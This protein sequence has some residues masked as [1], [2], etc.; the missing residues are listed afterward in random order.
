[1]PENV[2]I[3]IVEDEQ[4][5]AADLKQTLSGL[6]Y[7][8]V[9]LADTGE[10]AIHLASE[11]RPNLVLMDIYLGGSVNGVT[12]AKEINSLWHIP[13]VFLT[14]NSNEEVLVEARSAEPYGYL[15]KPYRVQELDATIRVALQ[16]REAT[17][18]LF[19]RHH[20]LRAILA[21]LSDGV[22]ATDNSGR[23]EYLNSV[24]EHLTGWQLQEAIGKDFNE[25]FAITTLDGEPVVMCQLRKAL[26]MLKPVGRAR[27]VLRSKDGRNTP[28]EDSAAPVLEDGIALGAVSVFFDI[29]ERLGR[30]RE[31]EELKDRLEE[32]VRLT[33]MALG[34][35][36][37]ELRALSGH[38]MTAQEEERRRIARELHDDLAQQASLAEMRLEQLAALVPSSDTVQ[39]AVRAI[40][41]PLADL[42]SGLREISRRLHPYIIEDLGLS[43]AIRELVS[44]FRG[45]GIEVSLTDRGVPS[46]LPMDLS[47]SLYRIAQ[48]ALRNA[49]K[50]AK[51]A[52]V[53]IVLEASNDHVH[54]TVEDAGPGFELNEVRMQGGLGLV[55]MQER[56]R[57]VGGNVLLRSRRGAGTLILARVP[58]SRGDCDRDSAPLGS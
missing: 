46:Q 36:R 32:Q 38:L 35:T 16:R 49:T 27:F 39:K 40:R 8:V 56:A 52:P 42:S 11:T 37:A 12:A 26:E 57:L 9:G 31:A 14:A 15:L 43:A 10:A 7:E 30:E 22:V 55:S 33:A 5:V 23:V 6:G 50:H 21:S 58:V 19:S 28:I 54:L 17:N 51:G 3:L 2:R 45:A 24:A 4:I 48:E 41:T 47:T 20:W 53:R 29:S 13:V 34:D 18:E 44:Q 1:M 25:V